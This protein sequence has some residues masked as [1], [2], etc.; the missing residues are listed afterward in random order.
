MH[1]CVYGSVDKLSVSQL[2]QACKLDIVQVTH[3]IPQSTIVLKPQFTVF[4][5]PELLEQSKE[6]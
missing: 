5:A 6:N 2:D 4:T 3:V 1:V